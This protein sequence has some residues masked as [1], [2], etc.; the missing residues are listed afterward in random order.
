MKAYFIHL[1]KN[2]FVAI[3]SLWN[4]VTHFI[5]GLIPCKWTEHEFYENLFKNKE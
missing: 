1:R 4:M 5:H 3:F 2:W